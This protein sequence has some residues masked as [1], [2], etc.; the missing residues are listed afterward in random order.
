MPFT[1]FKEQHTPLQSAISTGN[2]N[3]Y[4]VRIIIKFP[5]NTRC[6]SYGTPVP[7]PVKR[8]LI[9]SL[10][11]SFVEIRD[12]TPSY[13]ESFDLNARHSQVSFTGMRHH[14]ARSV[15]VLSHAH[16][17]IC[18]T[19]VPICL[20][21]PFVHLWTPVCAFVGRPYPYPCVRALGGNYIMTRT[22]LC[23]PT[24]TLNGLI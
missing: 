14:L 17:R 22:V 19:P 16:F 11:D 20:G 8:M 4:T 9:F 15:F 23:L 2:S 13:T 1:L 21:R 7:V 6:H 3:I 24:C 18:R 12:C 5:P 10:S